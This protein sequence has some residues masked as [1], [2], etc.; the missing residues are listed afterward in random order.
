MYF[1]HYSF[2]RLWVITLLVCKSYLAIL[3]NKE[4]VIDLAITGNEHSYDFSKPFPT[5]QYFIVQ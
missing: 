4:V 1:I 5:D 2:I 3:T